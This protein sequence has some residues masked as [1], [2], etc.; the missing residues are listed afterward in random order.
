MAL[1]L[2][3]SGRACTRFIKEVTVLLPMWLWLPFIYR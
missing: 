1:I 3:Q 2:W